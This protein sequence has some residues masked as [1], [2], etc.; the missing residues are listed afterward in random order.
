MLEIC[1]LEL[2]STFHRITIRKKIDRSVKIKT[3][4]YFILFLPADI[5]ASKTLRKGRIL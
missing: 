2:S 3:E 4:T 5:A 1:N